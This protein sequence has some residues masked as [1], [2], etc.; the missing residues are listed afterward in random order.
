MAIYACVYV[1]MTSAAM[2][3]TVDS[4]IVNQGAY[5][6]EERSDSVGGEIFSEP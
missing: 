6:E 4:M 2:N 1:R 3:V 5:F